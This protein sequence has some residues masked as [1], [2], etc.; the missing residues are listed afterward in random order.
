MGASTRG[1]T[2]DVR[3]DLDQ[4]LPIARVANLPFWWLLLVY[5]WLLGRQLAGPVAGRLTVLLLA[6]EPNLLAHAS[7]ATTDLAMT[8]TLLAFWF[9]YQGGRG[10]HW[11]QRVGVPGVWLG[12]C[13]ASK[14]SGLAFALLGM[15]AIVSVE[16]W[17]SLD[18]AASWR[19]RGRAWWTAATQPALRRDTLQMLALGIA[20][21][22]WYCGSDW[23]ACP[24]F[25]QWARQLSGGAL[26]TSM[27]WLAEHLCIF[28]N[29][30]T[31]RGAA[32][33]AT[34]FRAMAS[35]CSTRL[36]ARPL[37]LLPRRTDEWSHALVHKTAY[38]LTPG[39]PTD[40]AA[41]ALGPIRSRR[42]PWWP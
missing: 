31:A 36:L 29:A 35:S 33:C 38:D 5:G 24:S 28:T 39:D 9:H 22:F 37:V 21:T 16:A 41:W 18:A 42:G 17:T 23:Q 19:A 27:V 10:G 11:W 26:R 32:S 40:R 30:G 34:I 25:V 2:F 15:L 4:V 13:I 6:S 12:V 7:L 14:A 1:Q 8:A 3:G 20:L